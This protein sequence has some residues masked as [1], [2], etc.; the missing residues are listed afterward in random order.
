MACGS[1]WDSAPVPTPSMWTRV[2]IQQVLLNLMRNALQAMD[3]SDQR[4]LAVRVQAVDGM[5]QISVADSGSGAHRRSRTL[6][7]PF[8]TTK[9]YGM[10]IGPSVCRTIV[11]SHG[12]RLWMELNPDGSSLFHFT[13][14][15]AGRATAPKSRDARSG[16]GWCRC[17]RAT[18]ER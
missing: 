10:G 9:A 4:E 2:Q 16:S 12:G 13:V 11:E 8:V 7:Q 18:D 14:P 1:I 17:P 5:V 3:L 6:F 15:I